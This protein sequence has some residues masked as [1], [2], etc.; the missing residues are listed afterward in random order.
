MRN[1]SRR[2]KHRRQKNARQNQP[3]T[4]P[5]N[6]NS[7][8]QDAC[9]LARRG[10]HSQAQTALGELSRQR[11]PRRLQA[12]VENDLGALDAFSGDIAAARSRFERALIFDTDCRTARQNLVFLR[13]DFSVIVTETGA[14]TPAMGMDASPREP[15]VRI[16]IVSLLFNW[17]STG[18][19]TVHTAETGKFLARAGYEV[20]HI[21]ARY[22]GWGVGNVT[23][24]LEIPSTELVFETDGWNV[25]EIQRRF[26]EAVGWFEPD[27]VLVTDS[28]N[29]K[30][31]LAEA[32]RGHR[33][34]L[35]LAAQECLCTLN[36][37]RLLVDEQ[38]RPSA[39]PLNQLA[40][41]AACRTCVSQRQHQ[42]GS[43][44]QA[45]RGLSG[46][47]TAEYD[48]ILRQAFADAEGVLAVNPLIAAAVS[49][50]A[51]AVHVV[52]SGFD[53]DRF[54]WAK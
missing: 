19:G 18:G 22:A 46:Y 44:H 25:V 52:P 2:R 50:Y 38:G 9:D 7:A 45:E 34:F 54:P 33:Y 27:Y 6:L 37:V 14:R 40:T 48:E 32:V 20:K 35:R 8:Y 29:F 51:K 53:P 15:R 1:Q 10:Q 49:P 23:L 42:S 39:C 43:L 24:P 26:R 36:N 21:Y 13:N 28:W 30:P 12:L 17:P 3:A 11:L 47:G 4:Q 41:A 5:Q 31:I 16:A